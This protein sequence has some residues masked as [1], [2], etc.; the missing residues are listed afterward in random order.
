MSYTKIKLIRSKNK[1]ILYWI[2]LFTFLVLLFSGSRA[3]DTCDTHVLHPSSWT[4]PKI[5]RL[6]FMSLLCM[7]D[8]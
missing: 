4:F 8:G 5:Q 6:R 1:I 3:I 2:E 7:S